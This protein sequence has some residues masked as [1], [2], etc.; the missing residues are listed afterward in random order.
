MTRHHRKPKKLGG[1]SNTAN[2]SLVSEEKHRAWHI[3]FGHKTPHEIADEINKVW[4]DP[5]YWFEVNQRYNLK[6]EMSDD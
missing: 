3:L 1:N 5:H 6:R 2:I 4:L